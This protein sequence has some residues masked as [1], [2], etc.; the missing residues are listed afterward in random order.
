M[1]GNERLDGDVEAGFD[2]SLQCE[3]FGK[4]KAGIDRE[5]RKSEPVAIGR[6]HN[7]EASSLKAGAD[8]ST[9]AELLPSPRER[10]VQTGG[11]K[12]IR[13]LADEVS[14]KQ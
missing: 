14:V 10:V 2:L 4:E 11:F 13:F 3:G 8:G 6:V 5:N 9:L 12:L 7:D 1:L